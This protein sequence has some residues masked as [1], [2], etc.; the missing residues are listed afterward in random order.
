[1]ST[2]TS[3]INPLSQGKSFDH[4]IPPFY[5]FRKITVTP[6]LRCSVRTQIVPQHHHTDPPKIGIRINNKDLKVFL[7]VRTV[8]Q[9]FRFF[10][11]H[12]GT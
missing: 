3:F 8:S 6:F 10:V 4:K 12:T 2:H 7:Q 9:P 5:I 11:G 1:M